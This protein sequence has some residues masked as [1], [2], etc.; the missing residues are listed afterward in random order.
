MHARMNQPKLKDCES[1]E[2]LKLSRPRSQKQSKRTTST[3]IYQQYQN[4]SRETF[5]QDKYHHSTFGYPSSSADAQT[6][7]AP[8]ES[9]PNKLDRA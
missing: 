6:S 3:S 2:A 9:E 8:L 7:S 4:A 1:I 5:K